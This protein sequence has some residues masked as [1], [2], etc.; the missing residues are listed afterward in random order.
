[1]AG[2]VVLNDNRVIKAGTLVDITKPYNLRLK[3]SV[4]KYVSHWRFEIRKGNRR[5]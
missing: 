5:I 2:N 1:M 4:M 3:N